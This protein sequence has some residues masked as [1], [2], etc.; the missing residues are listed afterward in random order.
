MHFVV[1]KLTFVFSAFVREI[2]E[3]SAFILPVYEV[4]LV[5]APVLPF[6]RSFSI[7]LAFCKGSLIDRSLFL[8]NLFSLPVLLV[9]FPFSFI[10]RSARVLENPIPVCPIVGP[11][12]VIHVSIVMQNPAVSF[13]FA[14]PELALVFRSVCV[15][16][17]SK[18]VRL[19]VKVPLSFIPLAA[20]E[21]VEF[22][23]EVV[24]LC[25]VLVELI[26]IELSQLLCGFPS[27]I[28]IVVASGQ[29]EEGMNLIHL[30]DLSL[31]PCL[32]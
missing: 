5:I 10:P 15:K 21:N 6:E 20:I 22:I 30:Q 17:D 23:L 24:L 13:L 9:H 14:E 7:L 29:G 18:T 19:A 1:K 31:V 11:L 4:S 27:G 8:E 2:V 28:R 3:P 26:D 32:L 12:P 25:G 16:Q